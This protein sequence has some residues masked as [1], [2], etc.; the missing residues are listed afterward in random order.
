VPRRPEIERD[1]AGAGM[2]GR[3]LPL[4]FRAAARDLEFLQFS[5]LART[6]LPFVWFY[7]P[8]HPAARLRSSDS[9]S[10]AYGSCVR[11]NGNPRKAHAIYILIPCNTIYIA[12]LE[13][14]HG[15]CC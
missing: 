11:K 3:W 4:A 12:K 14:C 1:A 5:G 6:P 13:H 10:Y 15:T 9:G 7:T 2:R 8:R